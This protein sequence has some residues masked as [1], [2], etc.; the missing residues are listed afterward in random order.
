MQLTETIESG[1]T[2]TEDVADSGGWRVK[3]IGLTADEVNVNKR[4]YPAAVVERAVAEANRR[5][6]EGKSLVGL[7]EHPARKESL[8]EAVF[9][10]TSV[11]LAGKQVL[12]EGVLLATQAG[13]DLRA[14]AQGGVRIGISQRATGDTRPR[15]G[16]REVTNFVIHG[17]DAV[18]NP[19]DRAASLNLLESYQKVEDNFM[20]TEILEFVDA[21]AGTYVR[22]DEAAR[23][24]L[25]KQVKQAKPESFDQAK[26]LLESVAADYDRLLED[27]KTAQQKRLE[28]LER[29]NA[30]LLEAQNKQAVDEYLTEAVKEAGYPESVE[31]AYLAAVKAAAPANVDEAKALLESQREIFDPLAASAA[32]KGKGFNDVTVVGPVFETETGAPEFAK[33]AYTIGQRLNES[34]MGGAFYRAEPKTASERMTAR[35]LAMYDRQHQ[36]QLLQESRLFEAE[37]TSDTSIPFSLVRAVVAQAYPALTAASVYD[38]QT[39]SKDPEK[40]GYEVFTGETGYS[41]TVTNEDFNSG[42]FST[43]DGLTQGDWVQLANAAITPGSVVVN[44]DGGGAL[45]TDDGTNYVVDYARGRIKMLD[46]GSSDANVT[47]STAYEVDYT[48]NAIAKGEM[49]AI[50][51]AKLQLQWKTL[52]SEAKRLGAILSEDVI[53]YGRAQANWDAVSRTVASLSAQI[54]QQVDAWAHYLALSAALSV[55]SNSGGTVSLASATAADDLIKAVGAAKVKVLNRGYQPTAVVCSA[56]ISDIMSNSERFSAAGNRPGDDLLGSG[57]VGRVK[58]LPVFEVAGSGFP[59]DY[60]LV[61]NRELVI[62]R[63]FKPMAATGPFQVNDASTG[64]LLPAQEYVLTEFNGSDTPVHGKGAYV[65][66]TS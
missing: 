39:A 6:Q 49:A 40:I 42:A 43:V 26:Q 47:A 62:H 31:T 25:A 4:I 5:L 51:R 41:N 8:A 48:Y 11:K 28:R 44:V 54:S 19:S 21:Q 57:F 60:L 36:H 32:L 30:E 61:V 38:F 50:E 13:K 7:L 53:L 35:L 34:A 23:A 2:I 10:W 22:F 64:K 52:T 58:G 27:A 56:A 20:N 17:Y 33:V 37:T 1:L 45:I 29:Q 55:A 46:G 15:N 16:V 65:K 63:I 59:D 12:L 66:I 14:M 18:I 24:R 9:N 3:A